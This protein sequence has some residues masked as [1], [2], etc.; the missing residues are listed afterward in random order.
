MSQEESGK[1]GS[2]FETFSTENRPTCGWNCGLTARAGAEGR[3]APLCAAR[4][5][6]TEGRKAA[7]ATR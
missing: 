6:M 5:R 7:I 4:A 2:Y 3:N 1:I